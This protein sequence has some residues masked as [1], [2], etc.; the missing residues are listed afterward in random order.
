[1]SLSNEL[2]QGPCVLFLYPNFKKIDWSI[3]MA[4]TKEKFESHLPTTYKTKL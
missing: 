1:M 2:T 4:P 3:P